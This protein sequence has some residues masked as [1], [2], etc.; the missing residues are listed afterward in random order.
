MTSIGYMMDD[1]LSNRRGT[2]HA[3]ASTFTLRFPDDPGDLNQDEEW[4]EVELDGAWRRYRLHDY[5]EIFQIPG[6]YE[7]LVYEALECRSPSRLVGLFKHTLDNWPINLA[8]MRVLDVGA[9]NGIVGQRLREFGVERV[10]GVDI[11]PEAAD[12]AARD[13]PGAYDD[14][15]IADLTALTSDQIERLQTARLNCLTTVAALGFGDIPP[16]AFANAFNLIETPG[17]MAFTIKED[18][19]D[20]DQSGFARLIKAMTTEG[21]INTEAQL[22]IMHRRSLAGDRLFYLAIIARKLGNVSESMLRR[23]ER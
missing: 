21:V 16:R 11:I 19:L 3:G 5:D 20:D 15:L 13:Y 2:R 12:A 23:V 1:E 10:I 4:F 18:F 17:W 9:G 14:Y 7:A 22:R 8:D 6:L